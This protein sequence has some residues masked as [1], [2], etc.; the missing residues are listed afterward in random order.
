[1]HSLYPSDESVSL[2]IVYSEISSVT[3]SD[4]G[5]VL[6]GTSVVSPSPFLHAASMGRSISAAI[7]SASILVDSVLVFLMVVWSFR[8]KI[9]Q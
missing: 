1:M 8:L 5:C 4:G 6:S 7:N 3:A 9:S 2:I